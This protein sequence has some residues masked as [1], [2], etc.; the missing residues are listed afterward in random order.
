[1]THYHVI[2]AKD[3]TVAISSVRYESYEDSILAWVRLSTALF[4]QYEEQLGG[5]EIEKAKA[6]TKNG[7]GFMARVGTN[8][9]CFYWGRCEDNCY[10]IT[11][12]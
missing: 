2:A 11:W 5:L 4:S 1:M 7:D 12:N 6:A 3:V 8:A 9:L 10:S